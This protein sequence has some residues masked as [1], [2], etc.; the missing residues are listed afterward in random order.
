[1]LKRIIITAAL[2]LLFTACHE[3]PTEKPSGWGG[4]CRSPA[5][6]K[7]PSDTCEEGL[8][9]WAS[10]QG[11]DGYCTDPCEGPEDCR[12]YEGRES[13]C[14]G[15][16]N[17]KCVFEC[18]LDSDCPMTLDVGELKCSGACEVVRPQ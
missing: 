15:G 14:I 17:A 1:M 7:V 13:V 3:E 10:G 16:S 8:V 2:S 18:N 4:P 11:G 9:C 12:E 6:P 5:R